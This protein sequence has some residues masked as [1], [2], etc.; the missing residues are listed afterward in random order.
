MF[1][2]VLVCLPLSFFLG[3][4]LQVVCGGGVVVLG[5]AIGN[6]GIAQSTSQGGSS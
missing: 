1:V 3:V 6:G 5:C 4:S 2:V